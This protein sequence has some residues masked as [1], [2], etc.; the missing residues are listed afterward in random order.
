MNQIEESNS[1]H[2]QCQ[3]FVSLKSMLKFYWESVFAILLA[4]CD[5]TLLSFTKDNSSFPDL[6]FLWI[7]FTFSLS[8]FFLDLAEK[9]DWP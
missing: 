3:H 6:D 2:Q 7:Y 8:S 1:L 9:Q 5:G 4:T